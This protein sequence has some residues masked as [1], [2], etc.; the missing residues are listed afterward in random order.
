MRLGDGRSP[1]SPEGRA[2]ADRLLALAL[3]IRE[4]DP[5]GVMTIGESVEA[6]AVRLLISEG[7]PEAP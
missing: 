2:L 5:E 4:S 7:L 1:L 6:A 3:E